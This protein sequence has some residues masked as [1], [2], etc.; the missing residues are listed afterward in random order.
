[1]RFA[2]LIVKKTIH[3]S[4]QKALSLVRVAK[5]V[6]NWSSVVAVLL[7]D[8][9]VIPRKE[10]WSLLF[11]L[12][13]LFAGTCCYHRRGIGCVKLWILS[14]WRLFT[15]DRV[16]YS[17]SCLSTAIY[18][19]VHNQNL[20]LLVLSFDRY[21]FIILTLKRCYRGRCERGSK[22]SSWPLVWRTTWIWKKWRRNF[23]HYVFKTVR[24]CL[25]VKKF[26]QK[27][28]LIVLTLRSKLSLYN[29]YILNKFLNWL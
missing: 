7:L 24:C 2:Y 1:M 16:H 9:F 15:R 18:L 19:V 4:F 8:Y 26:C 5:V 22:S 23:S 27:I 25:D 13:S 10:L 29:C 20:S 3:V 11:G 28:T 21:R 6:N 14:T 17:A 12:N